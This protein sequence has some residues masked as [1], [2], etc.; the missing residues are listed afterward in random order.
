MKF[1]KISKYFLFSIIIVFFLV[2]LYYIIVIFKAR[3]DTPLIIEKALKESNITLKVSDLNKW[4]LDA[5]LAVEDPDFYKHNG[6][7]IKTPGA[8]LTTITQGL[9]KKYYF[10]SFKPGIAKIKQTLIALFALNP[11]VSKDDQLKLFI[12]NINLGN[13][14]GKEVLGFDNAAK[15]YFKK[16]F[17]KLTKDE[18]LS[19]VAMIIAPETFNIIKN[20]KANAKRT[21]RI[22]KVVSGEYRPKSLMDIYYGE[23]DKEEQKG[24]APASY[25]PSLYR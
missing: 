5:L 15:V 24:L 14:D 11:L 2:V 13:I 23:L 4:Q 25:Y 17:N 7:D 3:I 16:S 12:N 21:E 22:R 9:V 10:V 18:Y 20:P 19:I 6:V 8:G 1:N